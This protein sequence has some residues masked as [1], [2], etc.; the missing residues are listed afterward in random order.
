MEKTLVRLCDDT[1]GEIGYIPAI[2]DIV[3][4]SVSDENGCCVEKTGAVVEVL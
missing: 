3:T 2:G 1:C 4:I